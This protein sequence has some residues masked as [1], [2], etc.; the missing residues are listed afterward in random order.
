MNKL[1]LL[2]LTSE[3]VSVSVHHSIGTPSII[4]ST[5]FIQPKSERANH[6]CCVK[7]LFLK[8]RVMDFCI[9]F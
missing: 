2:T 9:N 7:I 4:P 3:I 8:A 6:I 5:L 1:I